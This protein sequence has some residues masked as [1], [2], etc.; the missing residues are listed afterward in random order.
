MPGGGEG[1]PASPPWGQEPACPFFPRLALE[2]W[3]GGLGPSFA[4][5]GCWRRAQSPDS[6]AV[7]GPGFTGVRTYG[8]GLQPP[9]HRH[10]AVKGGVPG[11]RQRSAW[12]GGEHGE[13]VCLGP[14]K[15]AKLGFKVTVQLPGRGGNRGGPQRPITRLSKWQWSLWMI[16][17]DSMLACLAAG[18]SASAVPA[19][20]WGPLHPSVPDSGVLYQPVCTFSRDI[21]G[22]KPRRSGLLTQNWA[23]F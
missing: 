8:L 16:P 5:K 6:P 1:R 12:T 20:P 13:W 11:I 14:L 23:V 4:L 22:A 19:P 3:L 9:G 2:A 18:P 15:G 7:G 10:P 21:A 17:T